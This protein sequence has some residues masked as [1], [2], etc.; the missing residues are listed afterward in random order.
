LRARLSPCQHLRH[1][2]TVL[3]DTS[4]L[5]SPSH[6][7]CRPRTLVLT[8]NWIIEGDILDTNTFVGHPRPC[9][10]RRRRLCTL[11]TTPK[12]LYGHLEVSLWSISFVSFAHYALRCWRP[13]TKVGLCHF[14]PWHHDSGHRACSHSHHPI[15]LRAWYADF[16]VCTAF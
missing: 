16:A 1:R 8:G 15:A 14:H 11:I 10:H 6:R 12:V 9:T 2:T 5:T 4:R 7:S 3:L 13:Q